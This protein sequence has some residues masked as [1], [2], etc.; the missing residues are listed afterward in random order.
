MNRKLLSEKELAEY[1]NLYEFLMIDD[2][3]QE[4]QRNHTA[5]NA[6]EYLIMTPR[7]QQA[8]IPNSA[9]LSKLL[10][11]RLTVKQLKSLFK[12]TGYEVSDRTMQEIIHSSRARS[13]RSSSKKSRRTLVTKNQVLQ[14][15]KILNEDSENEW[16]DCQVLENYLMNFSYHTE[17]AFEA[18]HADYSLEELCHTDRSHTTTESSHKSFLSEEVRKFLQHDFSKVMSVLD[19]FG[20][21]QF[22]YR[23]FVEMAFCDHRHVDQ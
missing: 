17:K 12:R 10:Q 13:S 1:Q 23:K 22:N 6:G 21:G 19:P 5:N 8:L 4:M 16:M 20:T 2:Y 18:S 7:Q 3:K 14:A 9:S 15:F 11:K